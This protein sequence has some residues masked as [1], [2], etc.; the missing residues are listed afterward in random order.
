MPDTPRLAVVGCGAAAEIHLTVLADL[1]AEVTCLVDKAPERAGELAERYGVGRTLTDYRD[2]VG[3]VDAAVL[4]LPHHLHAPVALDLLGGG[5]NVLV[6]KPMALTVDECD[7]MIAA[8]ERAGRVL[9]VGMA[10]R[11][12]DAG[13]F[14]K[15]VIERG[16]LGE[17]RWLDVREGYVY[18]WP[19]VSEFMFRREAGGGVLADAGA[20]ILDNLLW[21]LGDFEGVVYRDDA[22]G[23]VAADCEIEIDM[24][25][26][27]R[28]FVELSRTRRLRNTWV[29]EGTEGTLEIDTLFHPLVR[30]RFEGQPEQLQG[31][32]RLPGQ[33]EEE[34]LDCFSRQMADFLDSIREE[35]EPVVNGSEGRRFV[36]LLEA[37]EAN[38]RPLEL[39]WE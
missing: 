26:G 7:R 31:R 37:C 33:P 35:R 25:S 14:V 18:E 39:P 16:R 27:T 2:L 23:G 34:A 38:R 28:C 22:R 1:P 12:Y 21:W 36:E 32:V 5:L 13:R 19:V 11:F 6:E 30:W 15:R 20:H 10:R 4:A 24:A 3:E 29:L 17:L 8:A 9:A